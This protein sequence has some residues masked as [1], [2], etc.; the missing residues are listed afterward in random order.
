MYLTISTVSDHPSPSY[1]GRGDSDQRQL[2]RFSGVVTGWDGRE[3]G[4]LVTL[5]KP[6]G[7]PDQL[8]GPKNFDLQMFSRAMR[9]GRAPEEVLTWVEEQARAATFVIGHDV[10][11][12]L[13]ALTRTAAMLGRPFHAPSNTFSAMYGCVATG[14]VQ[15]ETPSAGQLHSEL[16]GPTLSECFER[17]TSRPLEGAPGIRSHAHATSMVFHHICRLLLGGEP[18]VRGSNPSC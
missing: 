8:T 12:D 1:Q 7:F 4:Q 6:V 16:G 10:H 13:T 11:D 5:V 9:S 18:Y 15:L 14:L 17:V 3:Q 2:V